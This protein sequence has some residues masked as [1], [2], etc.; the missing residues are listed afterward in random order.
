[1]SPLNTSEIDHVRELRADE[2]QQ[3]RKRAFARLADYGRLF[4]ATVVSVLLAISEGLRPLFSW[5]PRA[6]GPR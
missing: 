5:N 6:K 2:M 1:M 4:G 3:L